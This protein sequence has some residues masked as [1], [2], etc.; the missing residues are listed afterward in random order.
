[1]RQWKKGTTLIV[2]DSILAGIEE[3]C[4]YGNRSVKVR[5]FPCA[6]THDMCDFMKPL[7]KMNTGNIFLYVGI[8]NLLNETSRDSLNEILP[9]KNIIEKLCPTCEVTFSNLV[10]RSDNGKNVTYCK[11]C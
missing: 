10:Y 8:N 4:I 3:K 9:L 11:I 6:A 1:M 7:L 2:G 5:I